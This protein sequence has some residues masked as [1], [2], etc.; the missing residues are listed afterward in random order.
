MSGTVV[1]FPPV[2]ESEQVLIMIYNQVNAA[3]SGQK[4]ADQAADDLQ[5]E[6]E[7]FVRKAG[8]LK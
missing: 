7:D 2:P 1:E 4:S 5:K 6:V 8:Y 3:L